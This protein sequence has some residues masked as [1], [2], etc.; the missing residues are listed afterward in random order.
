MHGMDAHTTWPMLLKAKR[1]EHGLSQAE[2]AERLGVTRQAVGLWEAGAGEPS[3]V[4]LRG[5]V[6]ELGISGREL[7]AVYSGEPAA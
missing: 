6:G 3:T 2:L 7:E 5:L 1:A 4:H